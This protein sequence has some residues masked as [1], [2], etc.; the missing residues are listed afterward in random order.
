MYKLNGKFNWFLRDEHKI[1]EF[2]SIVSGKPRKKKDT[3][4][5]ASNMTKENSETKSFVLPVTDYYH[6]IEEKD[7]IISSGASRHYS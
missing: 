1:I 6:K 4:R 3:S 7:R 2:I 5:H